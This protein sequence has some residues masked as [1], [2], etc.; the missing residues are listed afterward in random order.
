MCFLGRTLLHVGLKAGTPNK[1]RPFFSP[2]SPGFNRVRAGRIRGMAHGSLGLGY[3]LRREAERHAAFALRS[4]QFRN[5]RIQ[6]HATVKAVSALRSAGESE[7]H[8]AF[9]LRSS[10]FRNARIQ[11]HAAVKAVSTLRS[12]GKRSATPLSHC[13]QANFETS[14]FNHTRQQKRCRR[15]ALPPHSIGDRFSTLEVID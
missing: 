6:P 1:L 15:F 10:Q 5:A 13:A 4:S 12:A 14:G 7:R 2:R 8:A 9:A 3:G 11:P